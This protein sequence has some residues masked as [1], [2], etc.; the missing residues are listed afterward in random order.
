[1]KNNVIDI[2]PILE[3]KK[4]EEHAQQL[5]TDWSFYEEQLDK[6]ALHQYAVSYIVSTGLKLLKDVDE[7][8]KIY[9]LTE[10]YLAINELMKINRLG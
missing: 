4:I 3:A 9:S 6:E 7:E 5:Y 10:M 2:T 1:M 8:F